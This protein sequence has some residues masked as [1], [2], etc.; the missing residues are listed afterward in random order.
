MIEGKFELPNPELEA[1]IYYL[2]EKESGRKNYVKSGYRGQFFYNSKD[3]DASQE[4]I[5]KEICNPGEN[6]K[7]RL[8]TLS[9]YFHVGQ[10]YVGQKFETREGGKTIGRGR[11]TKILRQD[12]NYWDFDLFFKNLPISDKPYDSQN[13]R[14]FIA[15]FDYGLHN[16]D[17]IGSLKFAK[18]LSNKYQMLSVECKL[19]D[20]SI[21]AR[22]LI[23][24]ICKNWKKEIQ[25]H[26]SLY[27]IDLK[28]FDRG[29]QFELIFAT[30]HN[31][32]L[33][34]KITINTKF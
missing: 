11:I 17:Q 33:T 32:F 12:F 13:I 31:M 24:E 22:P 18:T 15:D 5:D 6:V 21:E 7:V 29:F 14:S 1:E 26:N 2:S 25:F 28:H 16:I 23:D 4:F 8:Q 19:K 10:F 3:W 20:K 27:K 34:G 30:W 9:P